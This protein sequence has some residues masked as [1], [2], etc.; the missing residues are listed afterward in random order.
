MDSEVGCFPVSY[1]RHLE[2]QW[3]FSPIRTRLNFGQ[4]KGNKLSS[5][6]RKVCS[7][8]FIKQDNPLFSSDS[9]VVASSSGHAV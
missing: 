5:V 4:G 6:R 2:G 1:N 7:S 8:N 3:M 9:T